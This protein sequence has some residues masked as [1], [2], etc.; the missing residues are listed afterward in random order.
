MERFVMSDITLTD[1]SLAGAETPASPAAPKFRRWTPWLLALGLFAAFVGS[2]CIGAYPMPIGRAL[3]IL[4]HS[5]WP[6]SWPTHPVFDLKEITVMEII[7]PP[8]VLVATFCGVALG[9]SGTALQGMMRNPLVG[10]DLV[11]VTSGAAFGGVLAMLFD[12]PPIGII[13]LAFCGGLGAMAC[14]FGLA[15]LVHVKSDG[16]PLILA[17]FFIGA[18]FLACVGLVQFL[19]DDGKLPRLVYWLLGSFV[20]ADPVKVWMVAIPTLIGGSLLMLL[21]W[22]LNLLSL[23]DVDAAS[24]GINVGY[25]RWAII[26]IVALM[27]AAQVSVSGIVG[28]IGLVVP[29]CARMLVGPDHRR[30]MPTS[31]ILGGLFV[32]GLDDL[33]RTIVQAEIPTGVLTALFGTPI[34]CFLFWK[35]QTKGW[36]SN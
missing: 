17:G 25:L 35:T 24:L 10:P 1:Q 20:G 4:F 27:V 23:G 33:T 13:G 31:A 2:L 3:D 28:W 8:R 21:R 12:V 15:K 36:I 9:M 11:G 18:F 16:I 19:S 29:H 7:R 22:R 30:L 5:V 6:F 34:I 26:A 32:L 14:T